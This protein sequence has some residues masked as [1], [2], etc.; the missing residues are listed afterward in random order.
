[1]AIT[2]KNCSVCSK[3]VGNGKYDGVF[4]EMDC[5][6][7]FCSEDCAGIEAF[8]NTFPNCCPGVYWCVLCRNEYL[9]SA[10][11]HLFILHNHPPT[12]ELVKQ[13]GERFVD[14]GFVDRC[15]N[16]KMWH[17]EFKSC[18]EKPGLYEG[19]ACEVWLEE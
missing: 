14:G 13:F 18:T 12:P 1:M 2:M 10:N 19:Y 7:R 4:C 16:C 5:D 15:M 11:G 9:A 8:E 17:Y 6:R 3:P